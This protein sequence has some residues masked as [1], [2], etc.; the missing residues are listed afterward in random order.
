MSQFNRYMGNHF[1]GCRLLG[2]GQDLWRHRQVKIYFIPGRQDV[3]GVSDGVDSW[4][5]PA[6]TGIDYF[7]VPVARLMRE[8]SEG[9][10]PAP[11]RSGPAPPP[12]LKR[13]RIL[14]AETAPARV[15]LT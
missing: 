8:L 2:E 15:R 10:D 14:L 13:T 5:A 7:S 1:A 9:G 3:V 6:G 4:I 12:P 11:Y